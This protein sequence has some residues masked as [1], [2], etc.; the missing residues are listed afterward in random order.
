M[1]Q[2]GPRVYRVHLTEA[3]RAERQCRTRQSGVRPRTRDRLERVRLSAAGRSRPPIARR[4]SRR[5]GRV[6][7]WIQRFLEGGLDALPD[8]PHLG[9]AAQR[10]PARLAAL[11]P[12]L[13][14]TDRT[15]TA[16]PR[17]DW[18]AEP[19]G[20]R[21]TAD[22]FG[23]LV[24]RAGLSYQRTERRRKHQPDP[25]PVARQPAAR[26]ALEQGAKPGAWLSAT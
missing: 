24:R 2:E 3:Q 7:F 15:G 9:Q 8:H 20:L 14:P 4:L 22:P 17:A 12:A 5:E 23:F 1:G 10:T 25:E 18:L 6:R 26:Q 21:W 11:R 13:E 16:P 19:P